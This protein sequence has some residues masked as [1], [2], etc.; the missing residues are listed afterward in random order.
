[1]YYYFI[2]K[3][4]SERQPWGDFAGSAG[5]G[6]YTAGLVE[7]RKRGSGDSG[8][9]VS[10]KGDTYHAKQQSFTFTPESAG[11]RVLFFLCGTRTRD[12]FSKKR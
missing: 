3:G 1:M 6:N 12:D 2:F 4:P 7:C 9:D 5:E 8:D 11:E 10:M